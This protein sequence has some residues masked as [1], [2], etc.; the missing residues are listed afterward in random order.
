MTQD[1]QVVLLAY[2][3]KREVNDNDDDDIKATYNRVTQQ[4][5]ANVVEKLPFDKIKSALYKIK[6]DVV[7]LEKRCP[8]C[9]NIC[10]FSLM[11]TTKLCPVC[12][13]ET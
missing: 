9:C 6:K 12:Q 1:Q 13:G 4:F 8:V 3:I 11:N 5:P 7:P 10:A 2:K